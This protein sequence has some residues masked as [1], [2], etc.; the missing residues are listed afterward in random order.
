[1]TDTVKASVIGLH[2][3]A[4]LVSDNLPKLTTLDEGPQYY[5]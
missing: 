5:R 3:F 4:R 1:M 2:T